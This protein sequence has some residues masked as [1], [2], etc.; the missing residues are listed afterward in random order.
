MEFKELLREKDITGAQ[1]ARRIN[2]TRS[3]VSCWICGK[4]EPKIR[5]LRKIAKVLNVSVDDV[6]RCFEEKESV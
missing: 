5:D 6:L 1:L 3:C 4:S 2:R